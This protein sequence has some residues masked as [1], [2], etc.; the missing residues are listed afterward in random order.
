MIKANKGRVDLAG[1]VNTI[2]AELA[3]I[4][5]GVCY[6]LCE[7]KGNTPEAVHAAIMEAVR[8]GLDATKNDMEVT[9]A[10]DKDDDEIDEMLNQ[11]RD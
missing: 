10:N 7:E 8:L 2:L 4:V 11:I 1:K 6:I 9:N 5:Q 3:T